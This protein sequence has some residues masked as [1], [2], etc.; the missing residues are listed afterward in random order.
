MFF[1]CWKNGFL[2]KHHSSSKR[3]IGCFSVIPTRTGSVV[4]L[5]HF[6]MA[7]TVPPS[8]VDHGPK[9]SVLIIAKWEWPEMAKSREET[10]K[11]THSSKRKFVSG[12]SEWESCSPG[13]KSDMP[14]WQ[15]SLFQ[16]EMTFG[17]NIQIFGSK[18]HNFVPSN[19]LKPHRYLFLHERGLSS[20]G[21]L[22]WGYQKFYFHPINNGFLGQLRPNLA[23]N[24]HFWPIWFH[25][26][27]KNNGNKMPTRHCLGGFP[28]FGYQNFNLL[29]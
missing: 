1:C 16:K 20:I 28:L 15:K 17:P 24:W 9:L 23:K 7:Q 3:K 6:F 27:P 5:G 12:R 8:F 13:Y 25:A 26:W 18:L 2:A 14:C 21:S 10:Q 29:P 22:I 4:I 11:M 19:Q